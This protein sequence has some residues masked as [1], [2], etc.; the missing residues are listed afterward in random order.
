MA[1][2]YEWCRQVGTDGASQSPQASVDLPP[3]PKFKCDHPPTSRLCLHVSMLCFSRQ[4]IL[5]PFAACRYRLYHTMQTTRTTDEAI[6]RPRA[7]L[8]P[9]ATTIGGGAVE[10][11][12]PTGGAD[13]KRRRTTPDPV[14]E[15]LKLQ[16]GSFA[17][18]ASS[19]EL[20]QAWAAL[21]AASG[22]G[23]VLPS[24]LS[25]VA[26]AGGGSVPAM[27]FAQPQSW[28]MASMLYPVSSTPKLHLATFPLWS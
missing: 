11:A 1:E 6:E 28:P 9:P 17:A 15:W 12:A 19:R 2:W 26:A 16:A 7:K 14:A 22:G 8:L 21:G 24:P 3:D 13:H 20:S 10:L 4:R 25:L 18:G 27:S 5:T 23:G